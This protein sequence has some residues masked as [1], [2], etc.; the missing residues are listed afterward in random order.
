[1]WW[2]VMVGLGCSDPFVVAQ[3]EDT[4]EAFEKYLEENPNGRF[5]MEATDRLESL[6]LKKAA[7]EASLAAYD[8]YLE[9]F[10]EGRQ[11]DK[12]LGEREQ[13]LFVWAKEQN[14]AEGWAKFLEEYPKAD[15]KRKRFA[16]RMTSVHAYLSNLELGEVTQ[17][18][19]NMAEDPEG[20]LNGWGFEVD[21]TNQGDQDLEDVR[22]TIAYLGDNGQV[23]DEKEYPLVSKSWRMPM[24]D[25]R[26]ELFK[27]GQTRT[28]VWS[29]GDL[30]AAWAEK[31]TVFVSRIE[32]AK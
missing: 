3:G 22:L 21:V 29:D 10:P 13:F 14:S 6:Y 2:M 9:R 27:P 18:Q 25:E 15:K 8:A 5:R 26:R 4:I 32:K 11:R 28:W 30:P 31:V 1:M 23:L 24:E 17:K 20:P 19:V 7:D 12:A 16:Q